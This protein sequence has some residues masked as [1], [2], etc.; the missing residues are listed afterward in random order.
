MIP[1]VLVHLLCLVC[2]SSAR[3]HPG[4]QARKMNVLLDPVVGSLAGRVVLPCHFFIMS[5]SHTPEPLPLADAPHNPSHG[6]H[7]RIKWTKLQG[8]TEKLVLVAQDGIV[9]VG[10]AYRNRVWVPSN[11]LSAG[12]ASLVIVGLRASDA[13]VYRCEVMHGMEDSQDIASLVVTGVVFHY[14]A[15]SSRYT[16]DFAAAVDACRAAGA[17]IATPEQLTAAFEDGFDQCDAGWLSDQSVRYPITVPR[18]GCAGDLMSRAGVRTY[19]IRDPSETYDVYCFVDK[20][21]GEVFYPPVSDKLTFQEARE[22]CEKHDAVLASPGQ[23]FAAWRAGLN[24]CDYGWLSDGSVRYPV[25]IPRPQCGGG[26]LGV[27]TLYMFENQ[28]GYPDPTAQHGAFCF[29]AKLPEPTTPAPHDPD[30]RTPAPEPLL[31]PEKAE[32]Q[33]SPVPV[34]PH[35]ASPDASPDPVTPFADYDLPDPS[36][37]KVESVPI[38]GDILSPLQLPPLPTTRSKPPHLDIHREEDGGPVRSGPGES[39][40]SGEGGSSDDGSSGAEV[41]VVLAPPQVR[42]EPTS[43]PS[44]HIA[45]DHSSPEIPTPEPGLP[46]EA[47]P[48]EHHPAV[49]FKD[50]VTLGVPLVPDLQHQVELPVGAESSAKPPVHIIIV[51]VHSQ[52]QSVDDIVKLID[53]SQSQE[54]QITDLSQKHGE[55]HQGSGDIDSLEPSPMNKPPIVRFVN[56]KHEMTFKPQQPEEARGDQFETASPVQVEEE[57]EGVTPTDNGL[58]PILPEDETTNEMTYPTE[59]YAEVVT[60]WGVDDFESVRTEE[61]SEQTA[62]GATTTVTSYTPSASSPAPTTASGPALPGFSQPVSVDED[63][64]GSASRATDDASRDGSA[65]VALPT[66]A[67][68]SQAGVMT[69]EAEIGGTELPTF[70]PD[71]R[72]TTTHM[73]V[74]EGS[75]SGEDE[76]SGQDIYPSEMPMFT[77]T[78]PST[79]HTQKPQPATGTDDTELPAVSPAAELLTETGSGAEQP[80]GE[81]EV[82]GS[83]R[84][85]LSG[86][87][88]GAVFPGGDAVDEQTTLPTHIRDITSEPNAPKPS[89]HPFLTATDDQKHPAVVTKPEDSDDNSTHPTYKDHTE[90]KESTTESYRDHTEQ[91]ESTTE[92]YR[93]HIEQKKN[94]I[95]SYRDHTEQKESTIK[96]YR[97]HNEQTESTTESYRD[98]VEQRESITEPYIDH[99]EQR[100]STTESYRDHI[101]QRESTTEP[102]RDHIEQRESTTEPY[103]DHI[104]QRESTTEPYRDHIE[105]R[106]STTEPYRDHTEQRESTTE[107]YRDHIEQRESTTEPYRDHIEQRESTTEPYRDHIEQ[108]ESTTEPY[109][110][111]IEQRES[112]TEPYRDHIEQSESTSGSMT[113]MSQ[114]ILPTTSPLHTFDKSTHS[115]PEWALTPDP[116]ATPLPDDS[117]V[118]YDNEIVRSVV[119]SRPEEPEELVA[120]EQPETDP[121]PPEDASTE[122]DR[123]LLLCSTNICQ[124][125]G[126]CFKKGA[127]SFCTCAPGYTGQ[128]CE[129]DA[130]ECQSNPCL[131]GATCVDGVDSFSCLCLPSYAGELCEQDTEVCGFGWQKFQSH[132]YKYF[133]HRRPW[134]AAEKECRLH[135]AHLSSILSH[136]EQQFVNRLGND[137]QWIGLNDKMF[138]RDFRWTDGKPMQYDYWR[139]NQPDSFFQ[140]GEDCV[141]MIWHEGGQWNDV[142][143][144]Y[145]LTF[146][147]KK[148]TVSCGQPPTVR[149]ARAFGAMKPRY[150]IN[151]LLRYHCKQGF[152]QRHT[153]IVRCRPTGQWDTPRVTCTSPATYH[154]TFALRHRGNEQPNGHYKHHNHH[155]KS[156]QKHN[157]NQEQQSYNT[158]Q[159]SWNPFQSRVQQLQD[160]IKH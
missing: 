93:D 69:D 137:Y 38:R 99:I 36:L 89:M 86:E 147:C 29:K 143:C 20:L 56:G 126:T 16:L 130:D 27:R 84:P 138:E 125:G 91:K 92:S 90:Q 26:L 157:R 85:D 102:Y 105:Q 49:V 66:P 78:L 149:D 32:I 60:A 39:T 5:H 47:G 11:P 42:V 134:D 98:H 156:L 154:K 14:R 158:V 17:T 106:E 40:G 70:T 62:A 140:S 145:H 12:N 141:V 35:M 59:M 55:I 44:E 25:T 153:P 117:F 139:P 88:V 123:D 2:L 118:D 100:E 97:D 107:P 160:R 122:K 57:E 83:E 28:T 119:E 13:G 95:E 10:Q 110:D 111:H 65:D 37:D 144:N 115:I 9:K 22:E 63:M 21:H 71:T 101:E 80:S 43:R 31:H 116:A 133:S 109:R 1:R 113:D 77:S 45:P 3:P 112:T 64:E 96:S 34:G 30:S 94:T 142:P 6:E 58:V 61:P 146:T 135:G 52:N 148:G 73:Q 75:A 132:C 24:R 74:E 53:G 33:A 121:A 81:R 103:R 114:L 131:N 48:V 79:L 4:P 104:E 68:G 152:I 136:E 128:Q 151:S 82:P 23:L 50:N 67:A 87:I 108:R 46:A 150:E 120:T 129:I 155:T 18:P 72:E 15:R 19:G 124:N 127:Q 159:S 7:L 76:A 41:G 8:D 54:P 51:N